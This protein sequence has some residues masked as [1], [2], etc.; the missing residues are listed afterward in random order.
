M[1]T[2][3]VFRQRI[4]H[5]VDRGVFRAYRESIDYTG[6]IY[7]RFRW[8]LGREFLLEFDAKRQQ[9]TAKNILPEIKYRSPIDNAL[10]KFIVNH[11]FP[12]HRHIDAD[13]FA[14][15]YTNR[16]QNVSLVMDVYDGQLSYRTGALLNIINELF[17]QISL[18]HTDYLHHQLGVPEE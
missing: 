5:L 10:R 9:I 4:Q 18:C 13:R 7:V 3:N 2:I 16:K 1:E 6:K 17:K 11:E 14:L 12:K 8:I 15:S